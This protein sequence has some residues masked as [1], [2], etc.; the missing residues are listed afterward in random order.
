MGPWYS[1]QGT[2]G[3]HGKR[4]VQEV[5]P[6][7]CGDPQVQLHSAAHVRAMQ[8][9][10]PVLHPSLHQVSPHIPR[11][12]PESDGGVRNFRVNEL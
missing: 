10:L 4:K 6:R 3:W 7:S 9:R 5:Q 12:A 8:P 2:A 1:V 11:C